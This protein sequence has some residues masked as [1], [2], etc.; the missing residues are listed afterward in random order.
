MA[1]DEEAREIEKRGRER[2]IEISRFVGRLRLQ[3]PSCGLPCNGL[4]LQPLD[5]SL[6]AWLQTR[7]AE[8][9]KR[10]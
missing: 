1:G 3:R 6:H 8:E 2:E 9:S 5:S 4:L 10:R 7:L